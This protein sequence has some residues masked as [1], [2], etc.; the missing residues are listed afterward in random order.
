MLPRQSPQSNWRIIFRVRFIKVRQAELGTPEDLASA[1][2]P[3]S[4]AKT[5]PPVA[6]SRAIADG[7]ARERYGE[8]DVTAIGRRGVFPSLAS[9]G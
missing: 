6:P 3:L 4:K 2:P 8:G 7:G 5:L 1:D 9:G